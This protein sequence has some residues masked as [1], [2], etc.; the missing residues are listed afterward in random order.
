[1]LRKSADKVF[2]I[3]DQ[4]YFTL[5]KYQMPGNNI[6]YTSDQNLTQPNVKL[7]LKQ[8]FEPKLML[9]IEISERRISKP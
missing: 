4:S 5:T 6:Y 8:K 7:K 2:V 9:Y 1:M 3:D